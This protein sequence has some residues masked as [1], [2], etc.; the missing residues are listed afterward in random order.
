MVLCWINLLW[1][2]FDFNIWYIYYIFFIYRFILKLFFFKDMNNFILF[3]GKI[4]IL[5]LENSM[6]GFYRMIILFIKYM[7]VDLMY[8]EFDIC[9]NVVKVLL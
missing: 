8:Y 4:S 1:Y 7:F 5:F 3:G 2:L 9:F 6:D